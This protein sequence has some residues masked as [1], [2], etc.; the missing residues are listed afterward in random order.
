MNQ[1][2]AGRRILVVED[3]MLVA[4]LLEAMLSDLGCT[5]VGPASS[6]DQALAMLDVQPIDAALLDVNL[7]GQKSFPVADALAARG[8]LFAFST[9]YH[10][11]SLP[12]AYQG[13]PLLQKPFSQLELASILMKQLAQSKATV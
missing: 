12:N 9:G 4:W 8:V 7:N 10:K 2:L 6:V 1:A 5:V 3:E 11:D 13:F